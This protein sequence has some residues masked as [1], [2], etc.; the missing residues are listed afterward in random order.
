MII[1]YSALL[2]KLPNI[3]SDICSQY[4]QGG[5]KVALVTPHDQEAAL[6]NSMTSGMRHY[7]Y[8]CKVQAVMWPYLNKKDPSDYYQIS[9]PPPLVRM[10]DLHKFKR[11]GYKY[12]RDIISGT[13][14]KRLIDA[15]L[16]LWLSLWVPK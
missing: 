9:P 2:I 13:S 14:G 16:F 4:P 3:F 15:N 8:W 10:G 6:A 5:S 1:F 7:E 11:K 12:G